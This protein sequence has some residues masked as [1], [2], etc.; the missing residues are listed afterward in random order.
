MNE[1]TEA[2]LKRFW[3]WCGVD[4]EA[5]ICVIG[6]RTG[7]Y[8]GKL[9]YPPLDLNNL[10]KYAVPRLPHFREHLL[11]IQ[12]IPTSSAFNEPDREWACSI[13]QYSDEIS[14]DKFGVTPALA[15]F[16]AIQQVIT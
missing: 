15:L 10:F 2:E 6:D 4:G 12:F 1:P 11:T 7:E 3:E 5:E 14:A 13:R 16:W 8:T 9:V